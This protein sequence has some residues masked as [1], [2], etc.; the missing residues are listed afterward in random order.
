MTFLCSVFPCRVS[1]VGCLFQHQTTFMICGFSIT[2]IH[3]F[4]IQFNFKIVKVGFSRKFTTF[5]NIGSI[6]K[7]Q[8]IVLL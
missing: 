4:Y 7:I 5:C 6:F 8:E 3:K 2:A 1:C